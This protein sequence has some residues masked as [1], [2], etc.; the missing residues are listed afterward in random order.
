MARGKRSLLETTNLPI[1]ET[2]IEEG[3]SP[4]FLIDD[5]YGIAC[6]ERQEMLC[7]KKK[8]SR[9]IKDEYGQPYKIET[10]YMWESFCYTN[11]FSSC[12]ENYLKIKDRELKKE[13]LIKTKDYTEL[14][15]IQN[16][17]KQIISKA[18]S[19]DGD[20]KSVFT[21]S[22]VIDQQSKLMEEIEN[23][24]KIQSQTEKESDKL[25]QLIKEKR[26][27][28]ISATEPTKHRNKKED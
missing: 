16:E 2:N 20:N 11:S 24:K 23:L 3:V 17:I 5:K 12:I 26:S 15:N 10:Y 4:Y 9:T 8:S 19:T 27:L 1:V 6:D 14:I 21:I 7:R 13:R 22:K 25:L 18:L 28:I